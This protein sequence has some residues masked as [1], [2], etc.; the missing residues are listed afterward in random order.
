MLNKS[1]LYSWI[2]ATGGRPACEEVQNCVE[3]V[4]RGKLVEG[5]W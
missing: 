3:E 5:H 1:S 2:K 4:Q